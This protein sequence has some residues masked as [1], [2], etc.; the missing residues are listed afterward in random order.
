MKQHIIVNAYKTIEKIYKERMSYKT[1]NTFFQLKRILQPHI[2]FQKEKEAEIFQETSPKREADGKLTFETP[3]K[4]EIFAE[5][6]IELSNLDID[7]VFDKVTVSDDNLLI[8]PED[9]EGLS[10]FVNFE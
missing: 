6:I 8:S 5:K 3:E 9:I 1:A 2:D 10:E 4:K 7:L